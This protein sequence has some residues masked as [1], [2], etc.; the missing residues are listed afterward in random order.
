M[1]FANE[2]A[3]LILTPVLGIVLSLLVL[4][5]SAFVTS[6]SGVFD[7]PESDV[8]GRI[9]VVCGMV[10]LSATAISRRFPRL[11]MIVFLGT[12]CVFIAIEPYYGDSWVFGVASIVLAA[13]VY[14]RWR[15]EEDEI[16]P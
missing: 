1:G 14:V 11:S 16:T 12:G 9:G 2:K 13:L 8:A 10:L 7:R 15:Q 4:V 3:L 6:M 5:S